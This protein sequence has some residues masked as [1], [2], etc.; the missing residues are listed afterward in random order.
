MHD[1]CEYADRPLYYD[2]REP[3]EPLARVSEPRLVFGGSAGLELAARF[4]RQQLDDGTWCGLPDVA[5]K[6][7]P[8]ES[9]AV[10]GSTDWKVKCACETVH[11]LP[12]RSIVTCGCGR[13]YLQDGYGAWVFELPPDE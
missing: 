11:V 7:G 6:L 2:H 8:K 10:G 1:V 9:Y 5:R 3:A 4:C 12:L 13:L